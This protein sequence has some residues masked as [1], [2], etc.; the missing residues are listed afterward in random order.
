MKSINKILYDNSLKILT[1]FLFLQPII[2][3]LTAISLRVFDN[4][5]IVGLGIRFIFMIYIVYYNLFLTNKKNKY[6]NIYLLS[7]FIYIVLFSINI[8]IGKG[9]NAFSYEIK[10]TIK[11]FYFPII[12]IGL[13]NVFKDNKSIDTKLLSRV[14]IIYCLG[15]LIPNI[16]GIGFISYEVTKSGS[17]GFFYTA[18]EI[19]A[20]ISIL[21]VSYFINLY[22]DK[23]YLYLIISS[24]IVIYLS[25]SIGTKGPLILF[26]VLVIY[27]FIKY[28]KSLIKEKKYKL[29]SMM[30]ISLIVLISLFIILLPRTNFY[31]NI[32]IHLEFLKVDSIDDIFTNEKVFDHFIFS[33][34]LSFWNKTNKIYM[35]SNIS[36]KLLGI[37]YISDYATDNVSMKMV[38]MDFVDIF[39]RHGIIGFMVYM[40]SLVWMLYKSF[41]KTISK[42]IVNKEIESYVISIIFSLVLALI[43]GH[44]L[45]A[46]A[47]SIF[48]ALIIN[49]F[50]NQIVGDD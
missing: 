36:D 2:D 40:I 27:L 14:F 31:K 13:V 25:T 5:F 32:V 21:M 29:F 9:F 15:V 16:L 12:L 44:V 43:T 7:I 38:E 8:I 48:V 26:I 42:K 39:Y 24:L 33:E 34:R 30:S 3:M 6:I 41:V 46:P 35:K 18:N 28:L 49:L 19:G 10:S 47:V 11:S 20:I 45:V 4:S 17:I 37:G 23:R 22:R 1:V 50:Y